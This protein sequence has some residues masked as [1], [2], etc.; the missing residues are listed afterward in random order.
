VSISNERLAEIEAR[1]EAATE[2]PW[3]A[4]PGG[5]VELDEF[6]EGEHF[7]GIADTWNANDGKDAEFIA[8]ARQDVPDL[9][10]T[11]REQAA[12]IEDARRGEAASNAAW[13]R[14]CQWRTEAEAERDLARAALQRV[15]AVLN[16]P[17]GTR[18][19]NGRAD[20]NGNWL[21]GARHLR[22]AVERA[23]ATGGERDV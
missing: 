13:D 2:G 8:H 16:G 4:N 11:V 6:G 7:N 21:R 5:Y 10:A 19:E 3:Y 9:I 1:C 12:E 18:D 23:L 20:E 15:E 17:I 14:E 22:V